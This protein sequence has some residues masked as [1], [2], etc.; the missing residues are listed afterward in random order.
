M[1]RKEHRRVRQRAETVEPLSEPAHVTVLEAASART[2]GDWSARRTAASPET[3]CTSVGARQALD[4]LA[5]E[6]VGPRFLPSTL[7][8]DTLWLQRSQA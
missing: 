4:G 2:I 8:K 5:V 6:G 1:C 3:A 7:G